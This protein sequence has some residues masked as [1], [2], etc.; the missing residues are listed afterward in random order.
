MTINLFYVSAVLMW[1]LAVQMLAG[2][3]EHSAAG[4]EILTLNNKKQKHL[5]AG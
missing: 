3:N 4:H 2:I 5:S 1:S